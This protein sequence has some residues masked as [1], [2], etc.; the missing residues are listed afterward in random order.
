MA[1]HL[2]AALGAVNWAG[3]VAQYCAEVE[4]IERMEVAGVRLAVWSK[5]FENIE[6]TRVPAICFIREMQTAGHLVATASALGCYKLAASGMR[7]VV[8]TALYYSYFRIHEVELATLLRDD[9]WYISKQEILDYHVL[10]TPGFAELQKK[11][12]LS[13]IL[14]PW[15][16]KISAIIHGQVP[17]TWHTQKAIIDIKSDPTLSKE[18]AEQFEECVRIVDRLFLLTVGRELWGVFSSSAKK[19]LL[20][21]VPGEIKT[22]LVLDSA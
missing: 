8:E 11:F 9:K 6:G 10:H 19:R 16:N 12:P 4:I 7:T 5:Q 3:N 17:G 14:N 20:R 2:A 22:L 13:A 15:Y 18:V 21:G 1:N